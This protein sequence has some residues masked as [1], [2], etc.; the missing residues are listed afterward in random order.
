MKRIFAVAL[1][2]MSF[3]AVAF[4]DGS[5][6]I[7]PLQPGVVQLADGSGQIPPQAASQPTVV[8]VAG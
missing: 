4:A 2:L 3:A 8:S 5:G 6:Q 1:L 7:P